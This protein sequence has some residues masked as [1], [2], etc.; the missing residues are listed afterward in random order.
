[1]A[2]EPKSVSA[3]E[4]PGQEANEKAMGEWQ[5]QQQ[6][7]Q[8]TAAKHKPVSSATESRSRQGEQKAVE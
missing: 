5:F 2:S 7:Q 1:M 4:R 6:F 8:S 3:A